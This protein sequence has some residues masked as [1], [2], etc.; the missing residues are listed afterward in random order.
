MH[1]PV[2]T[3]SK[4]DDVQETLEPTPLKQN[5]QDIRRQESNMNT[6]K[7]KVPQQ[8]ED[9]QEEIEPLEIDNDF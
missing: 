3:K 9:S 1:K 5:Q 2:D 6:I 7:Q 4:T 8:N